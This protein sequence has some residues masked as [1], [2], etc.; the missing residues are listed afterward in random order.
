M[1][2]IAIDDEPLALR[3]IQTYIARTPQL[4]M[5]GAFG[6]ATDALVFL[7]TEGVDL[8]FVDINMPD[9][10]GLDLV[11]LLTPRPMIIFT[12][13]YSEYAI[14][15]FRLDAIDYILKPF[16]YEDFVR[17]VQK[18]ASLYELVQYKKAVENAPA[19][20]AAV[21]ESTVKDGEFLSVKADRKVS[22]VRIDDIIYIES[23]GEYVRL[24]LTDGTRIIT[25]FRLKNMLDE[26]PA[27]HFMRVHRSYIVNMQYVT[28]YTKGRIYLGDN[29]Y[30]PIGDIYKDTFR[31]YVD[32]KFS[33]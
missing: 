8:I 29:D 3:Q 15:G 7:G 5:R 27:D 4:E 2:C 6:S 31:Q 17:S 25:L 24:H 14:D 23:E 28:A 21:E 13:A 30:I 19:E 20:V 9:M 11:R 10:N 16:S 12:T 33:K 32:K 18:A 26:L 1:K 22:L